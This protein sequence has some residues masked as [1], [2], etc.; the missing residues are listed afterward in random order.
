MR[1]KIFEIGRL[2]KHGRIFDV[3]AASKII[4]QFF[5]GLNREEPWYGEYPQPERDYVEPNYVSHRL[6]N[7]IVEDNVL[8]G[9]V[10]PLM[11][12]FPKNAELSLR[13][14]GYINHNGVVS[15]DR[16][17]AFDLIDK[18]FKFLSYESV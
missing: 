18:Q 17:I 10:I 1:L 7:L 14:T 12:N 11:G 4:D 15:V 13:C 6:V 9:E 2:T 16:I 8:Y 3:Q 5:D